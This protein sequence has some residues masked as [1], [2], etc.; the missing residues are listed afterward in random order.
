MFHDIAMEYGVD[1][2]VRRS[3]D[4]NNEHCDS[5]RRGTLSCGAWSHYIP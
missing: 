1:R 3:R 2:L 5:C 4:R